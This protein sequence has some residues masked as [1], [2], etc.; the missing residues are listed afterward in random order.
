MSNS[1]IAQETPINIVVERGGPRETTVYSDMEDF[2]PQDLRQ[3]VCFGMMKI[4][5]IKT[6]VV[7]YYQVVG[8]TKIR[9]YITVAE[10]MPTK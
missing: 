5:S 1:T 8:L 9:G 3:A 10:M 7:E 4:H 6:L 2:V